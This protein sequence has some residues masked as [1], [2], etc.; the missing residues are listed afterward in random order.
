MASRVPVWGPCRAETPRVGIMAVNVLHTELFVSLTV[1]GK[2]CSFNPLRP[3]GPLVPNDLP[4][5]GLK[6]RSR[7]H[8][9]S[10]KAATFPNVALRLPPTTVQEPGP[11]VGVAR[12]L[13]SLLSGREVLASLWGL[14]CNSL[15]TGGAS[16]AYLPVPSFGQCLF[17]PFLY[18]LFGCF[19]FIECPGS[20]LIQQSRTGQE[21]QQAP[22][23]ISGP[24]DRQSWSPGMTMQWGTFQ[25]HGK[26]A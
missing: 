20:L 5:A 10:S 15:R 22:V 6:G 17:R 3:S 16:S 25:G 23:P 12:P 14:I 8:L 4:T 18:C 24:A 11:A 19:L 7:I 13:W 21:P 9:K 26:T 2:A 1:T